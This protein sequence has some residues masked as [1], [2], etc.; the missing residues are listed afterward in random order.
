[1]A[2]VQ[3]W[4]F[5]ARMRARSYNW[6]GTALAT[7]RL[8]AAVSEIKKVA[9]TDPVAAGDGVVSLM[10]RIWPAFQDI[11]TSS[12]ALGTA[13][14]RTLE[15]LIPI[16]IAA[17]ADHAIT[18][19]WLERLFE[20]VQNDGV[21]YLA[22]V[23]D[24]WG[25][26]A[27]YP[28]LINDYADR[29]LWVVRRAWANHN[30]FEYVAGTSICLSCLLEAG[31]YAE[32]QELLATRRSKF[33]SWHRFGAEA[34]VRQ[35]LW[36]AAIA[37]AASVRDTANSPY[38]DRSIDRFCED[39]LI[40]HGRADEAYRRYGLVAAGGTTNLATFRSL[41]KRYP[42]RDRRQTLIDLIKTRGDQ[43]KW[44][45]A[46][47]DAGFLDIALECAELSGVDPSTLVRAARDF[48]D[49]EPR[50]AAVV[51][52]LAIRHLLAGGGYDPQV[53]E[54]AD[55]ATHLLAAARQ[56]GAVDWARAEL[57]KLA[58]GPCS[59]ERQLFRHAVEVA[60][61]RDI[62]GNLKA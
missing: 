11:D 21:Q 46:A 30:G 18:S 7:A 53:S 59:S 31:R 6:R 45:A 9:K 22:P 24:R 5:K 1:M 62:A 19:T 3:K 17:P 40:R 14:S 15:E 58:D 49:K 51:G 20:A 36:E 56:I 60:L 55:A 2:P 28:D 27:R 48:C 4:Q 8:K 33:W 12:G 23:E 35:G 16:L 42:D 43:G 29:L 57:G 52:L 34:L 26:I 13:V 47:K 54:A 32:L 61:A 41:T 38:E 44:F 37:F 39:L 25:E 50:F 10:E